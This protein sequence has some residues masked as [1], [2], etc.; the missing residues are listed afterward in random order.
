MPQTGFITIAAVVEPINKSTVKF[1]GN[2]VTRGGAV[3]DE[4]SG[5][6]TNQT[7]GIFTVMDGA[8][9]RLVNERYKL[10]IHGLPWEVTDNTPHNTDFNL[11]NIFTRR[12]VS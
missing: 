6:V 11:R 2:F 10:I 3:L 8:E 12:T 1:Q 4:E 5:I 9:A 7:R